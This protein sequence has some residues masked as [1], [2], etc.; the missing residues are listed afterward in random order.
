MCVHSFTNLGSE[1]MLITHFRWGPTLVHVLAIC[2]ILLA[3]NRPYPY[4]WLTAG[5]GWRGVGR[6]QGLMRAAS[7]SEDSLPTNNLPTDLHSCSAHL[8]FKTTVSRGEK[9]PARSPSTF[10]AN[11]VGFPVVGEQ[12][13]RVRSSNHQMLHVSPGQIFTGTS[14]YT[15]THTQLIKFNARRGARQTI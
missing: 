10:A 14:A 2:T 8:I 15:Q 11:A 7:R 6:K 12:V 5:G 1:V 4:E 9:N 13:G 3:F